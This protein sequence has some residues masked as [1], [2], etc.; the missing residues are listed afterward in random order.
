MHVN[1]LIGIGAMGRSLRDLKED[2]IKGD[3]IVVGDRAFFFKAQRL[4]DL[5]CA[6]FSP[7]GLC[8]NGPGELAVMLEQ[9]AIEHT[10]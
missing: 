4:L 8:L 9:T 7:G 3:G 5:L 10:V 6:G 1:S 2:A